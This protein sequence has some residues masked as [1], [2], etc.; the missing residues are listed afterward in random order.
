[1][2]GADS[3][4]VHSVS[5]LKSS[6]VSVNGSSVLTFA[7]FGNLACVS[8]FVS[9]DTD[10][11]RRASVRNESVLSAEDSFHVVSVSNFNNTNPVVVG[12][13]PASH[14]GVVI[15]TFASGVFSALHLAV[16]AVEGLAMVLSPGDNLTVSVN[17][18]V[19]VLEVF[20]DHVMAVLGEAHVLSFEGPLSFTV[21]VVVL[22]RG[23]EAHSHVVGLASFA[24][25]TSFVDGE[26]VDVLLGDVYFVGVGHSL[27]VDN[28]GLF[29]V[30]RVF[31]NNNSRR[32]V[33]DVLCEFDGFGVAHLVES[34]SFS[35][36]L[37]FFGSDLGETSSFNFGS[38]GF[39]GC[40]LL[41]LLLRKF[42]KACF[43]FSNLC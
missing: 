28:M 3:M 33:L 25:S 30:H 7:R 10:E 21:A 42:G 18:H 23:K 35:S 17:Q 13:G 29:D 11:V 31:M 9:V 19:F 38:S 15:F 6:L 12:F 34:I 5:V 8:V 24:G 1:M 2:D 26:P 16:H 41:F 40:D 27:F 43:F 36:L 14:Q 32:F 37:V 22:E 20:V 39:L 4:S